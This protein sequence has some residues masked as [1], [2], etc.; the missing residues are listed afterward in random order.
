MICDDT[1]TYYLELECPDEA[2]DT[3]SEYWQDADN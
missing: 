1:D 3:L 2:Y